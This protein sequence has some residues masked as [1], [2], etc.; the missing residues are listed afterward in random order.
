[1][2]HPSIIAKLIKI[3][4]S[5][6]IRYTCSTMKPLISIIMPAYNADSHLDFSISSVLNQTYT[7][8]ELIIINDGSTDS[9]AD[10]LNKWSQKDNRIRHFHQ[11]NSGV[12][13][14][15]NFALEL[16][17]GEY[18]TMIDADDALSPDALDLM[19][20]A[21][22]TN[23]C[24]DMVSVGFCEVS[25]TGQVTHRGGLLMGRTDSGLFQVEDG[26][27]AEYHH[28]SIWG[29]LLR[30][31]IIRKFSLLFNTNLKIAE[32]HIFSLQYLQHC[33]K[34]VVLQQELYHYMQWED[35]AMSRFEQ[36]VLPDTVYTDCAIQ[37]CELATHCNRPWA[38]ALLSHFFRT[39]LWVKRII[40]THRSHDWPKIRNRIYGRLP[41]LCVRAGIIGSLRMIKRWYFT[42]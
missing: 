37:Y 3:E 42:R 15:R 1:M 18:I 22:T 2:P 19:Y 5:F 20:Q 38:V 9:T 23:E 12:S 36:A 41:S 31:N 35:S 34:T 29:K 28:C 10:I 30:T 24:V 7:E 39:T 32:D 17:Q 16:V 14:A 25:S 27:L 4:T 11:K 13:A 33:R 6:I 8:W 26:F 21:M 40:T